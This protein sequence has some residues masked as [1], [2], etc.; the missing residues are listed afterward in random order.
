MQELDGTLTLRE[1]AAELDVHYMTA[2]KYVRQGQLPA[3]KVGAVWHVQRADL[4]R[5]REGAATVTSR[6]DAPWSERLEARLL[7]SDQS[8]AWQV[9]ESALA[10]GVEPAGVYTEIIGPALRR[11]GTR[12]AAGEISIGEEHMATAVANRLIGRLGPRFSRRG[13]S[14]GTVIAATPPGERHSLGLEMLSDI[15]RGAGYEVIGLGSDVPLESLAHAVKHT[16]RLVAVCV[17]V[18]SPENEA[19]ITATIAAVRGHASAIPVLLGGAAVPDM[20]T[21]TRL[22]A[23]AWAADGITAVEELDRL[24]AAG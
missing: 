16:D 20:E 11:I 10:S 2:Y 22:G 1:A 9:I 12:W 19:I 15:L 4:D 3:E 23:D 18:M 7:A 8:G 17:S 14:R 13:R 24:T 5:F 6:G 21:A